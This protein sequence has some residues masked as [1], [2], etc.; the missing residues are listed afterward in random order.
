M[1]LA[2]ASPSSHAYSE[3]FIQMQ[4]QNLPCILRIHGQPVATETIPGGPI[5]PLRS[6]QGIID[7]GI[8]CGLHGKKWEGPQ[9]RELL[10]RLKRNAIDTILIN[11]GPAGVALMP[12]C[13]R[14]GLR[15]VVHFHGYDAHLT[16]LVRQ[17]ADDYRLLGQQAFAVVAVSHAMRYALEQLGIPGE[18]ISVVRCGVDSKRFQPA[19]IFPDSPLFVGVGRFV[20]KKAPYLT[21]LAFHKVWNRHPQARL[22]LIGDGPLWETTR[23]LC[24][25]LGMRTAVFFPGALPPDEVAF[26][27][28]AATAY[29]QHS[30]MP[31]Y[32]SSQG[33]C[34]G[35]PVAILEAMMSGLPVIATQHTGI[36][37]VI[38]HGRTGLLVEERDVGGMAEQMLRLCE[39]TDLARRIGRAAR[40]Y[41]EEHLSSATYI[42]RITDVL[43]KGSSHE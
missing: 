30:I 21:L 15:T 39:S 2:I 20:D 6:L 28:Q 18:K 24:E 29:V 38:E 37:E 3:T 4:W 41:A 25:A 27:M 1:R 35:T 26:H 16:S 23:N 11:Y 9:E 42:R 19:S 17:L 12:T 13:R 32:G 40:D 22:V 5:E 36:K 14:L 33:D 43:L 34:E 7:T 10:R 8:E 31:K